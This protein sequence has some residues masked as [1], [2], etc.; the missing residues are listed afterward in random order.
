MY[1][2]KIRHWWNNVWHM[3]LVW[4]KNVTNTLFISKRR[5]YI[6]IFY[7]YKSEVRCLLWK[8]KNELFLEFNVMR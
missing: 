7:K 1:E 5:V 3:K 8:V 6:N 2:K 4:K